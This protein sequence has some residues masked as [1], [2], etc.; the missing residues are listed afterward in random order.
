MMETTNVKRNIPAAPNALLLATSTSSMP[1]MKKGCFTS[2]IP[3]HPVIGK[4]ERQLLCALLGD[5]YSF[6]G[7][8]WNDARKTTF[9]IGGIEDVD[10]AK[11]SAFGAVKTIP[12]AE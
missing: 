9:F 2:I 5:G 8:G 12:V 10:V 3:T 7:V 6:H 11:S 1:P 4:Y